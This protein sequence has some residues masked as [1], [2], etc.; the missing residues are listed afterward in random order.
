MI[1]RKELQDYIKYFKESDPD[2]KIKEELLGAAAL[3]PF[4]QHNSSPRGLMMS[5]HIAQSLVLEKPEKP[6]IF[7][8]LEEEYGKYAIKKEFEHDSE[9]IAVIPR[10]SKVKL[11]KEPVEWTII[12]KDLETGRI[13]AMIVP[14]YNKFHPYF[15]FKFDINKE[16]IE[17]LFT[18]DVIPAGTI[19]AKPPTLMEDGSYSF[20]V[21]L[22]VALMSLDNAAEDAVIISDRALEKLKFRLFETRSITVGEY[23]FPL[24]IYGDKD[25]Y[26]AFPELYEEINETGA[27]AASRK[28]RDDLVPGLF[29]KYDAMQFNPI[30][31]NVVYTRG[32]GGR[33]VDIKVIKSPKKKKTLPKDTDTQFEKY[34]DL[35]LEYYK[36]VVNVYENLNKQHKRL[37]GEDLVVGFEFHRLVAEAY[38]IIETSKETARIKKSYRKED[39]DI[40]RAEFVIEYLIKPTKGF[41]ITDRH[42][43]KGVISKVVKVEVRP[44]EEMPRD[45]DGNVADIVLDSGSTVSRLNVGRLYERYFAAASRKAKKLLKNRLGNKKPEDL[46]DEEIRQVFKEN[47]LDFIKLF[48]TDQYT[49]FKEAYDKNDIEA[50]REQIKEIV[51]EEFYI[52]YHNEVEKKAWEIVLDIEQSRFKPTYGPVEYMENGKKYKTKDPIMI[53]PMHI[54]LLNKIAD[55]MLATASAKVN[56]FGLPIGVS[57]FDKYRLPWRNSPVRFLGEAETRII[58]SYGGRELLAELR[59]RAA[60]IRTHAEVYSKILEAEHPGRIENAVDRDKVGFE[61]DKA[62]E[63]MLSLFNAVGLD[64]EYVEDKERFRDPIE[65]I[66][67]ILDIDEIEEIEDVEDDE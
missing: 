10:Y 57:K 51:E 66:S 58:A 25:N 21:N 63:V 60:S 45:A 49:V 53:A 15:G 17:S 35:L 52:Y 2:L 20:G 29:S 67:E 22:N 24:N 26:K 31:D 13:D 48:E 18:G 59:D 37:T 14:Y 55:D 64:L 12:Y 46:T 11:N 34:A 61:H 41:K 8:G 33:V 50:M 56:Q 43:A 3:N 7:T 30:F 32:E 47:V 36:N 28:Y 44:I 6:I 65:K 42:G 40:Y 39:L 27:V 5:N 62:R 23:M 54:I 9:V 38:T 16:F 1:E 4:I 19:I